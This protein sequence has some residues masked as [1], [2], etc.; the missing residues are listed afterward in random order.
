MHD[1]LDVQGDG[2]LQ[3]RLEQ[4]PQVKQYSTNVGLYLT[5]SRQILLL[6]PHNID[7]IL[8]NLT[9]AS[10]FPLDFTWPLRH[11]QHKVQNDLIKLLIPA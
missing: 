6:V 3:F 9:L 1:I 8:Y 11:H 5:P 4:V 7:K 10:K 2:L